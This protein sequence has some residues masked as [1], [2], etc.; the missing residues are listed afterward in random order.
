M[1]DDDTVQKLARKSM[2]ATALSYLDEHRLPPP[3]IL[4]TYGTAPTSRPHWIDNG[5]LTLTTMLGVIGVLP[6][7][8]ENRPPSGIN[9]IAFMAVGLLV[10][11][12][13][14]AG[15]FHARTDIA[16]ALRQMSWALPAAIPIL[17]FR[18]FDLPSQI[19]AIGLFAFWGASYYVIPADAPR[20]KFP[21]MIAASGLFFLIASAI[22]AGSGLAEPAT[23]FPM[24]GLLAVSLTVLNT[25]GLYFSRATERMELRTRVQ[26]ELIEI[27]QQEL[28]ELSETDELTGLASRKQ[29]LEVLE[30][31][32]RR[33]DEEPGERWELSL[34]MVDVDY[35]TQLN[36]HYGRHI[37]DL[38]LKRIASQL[39]SYA[40]TSGDCVARYLGN[41]FLLVLHNQDERRAVR[42][43]NKIRQSVEAMNMLN[44]KSPTGWVVTVSVGACGCVP[45]PGY[46]Y[47]GAIQDVK[48]T[49]ARAKAAG[50]NSVYSRQGLEATARGVSAHAAEVTQLLRD[51]TTLQGSRTVHG[52][53]H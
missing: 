27:Q 20:L 21:L 26:H 9:V 39:H 8:F 2:A 13:S 28:N 34:V 25:L 5:P 23:I 22:S 24:I 7:L 45:R 32:W 47:T 52:M 19:V 46:S 30:R 12:A 31:D 53:V 1:Q 38:C 15:R 14:L 17:V 41:S 43:A 42:L 29:A 40:R 3:Q 50:R 4:E 48:S 18:P 10:L 37:G 36:E 11:G 51:D 6:A 49:L 33:Y 35:L 44:P 16:Q